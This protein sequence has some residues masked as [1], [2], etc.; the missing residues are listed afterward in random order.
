[1]NDGEQVRLDIHKGSGD[2]KKDEIEFMGATANQGKMF[3]CVRLS[4]LVT[5]F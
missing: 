5:M 2:F 1:M 3:P 4:V